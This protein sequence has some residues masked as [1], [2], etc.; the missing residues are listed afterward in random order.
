MHAPSLTVNSRR[1]MGWRLD[2]VA[3]FVVALLG[4]TTMLGWLLHLPALTEIR[5][6]LVPMVFNTGLGFLLAGTALLLPLSRG[7]QARPARTLIASL[8]IGLCGLT[9]IELLLDRSL[10]GIDLAFLHEW[11]DYGN[12]RPGRMA[13]N[14][15]L[16]F[17]VVAGAILMAD[18]V[19][20]RATAL[21]AIGLTF[22][23]LAIGMTGLVGYLLA[24]DLLFDWAR[25][26]RMALHTASGMILTALGL[27]LAWSRSDWY[28]SAGLI[29][30]YAKVRLLSGAILILVTLTAALA[31]F[32]LQ[33]QSVESALQ[34]RMA[35]IVRA[36][37][38]WLKLSV[39]QAE[40]HA[41]ETVE[42]LGL[43]AQAQQ[44]LNPAREALMQ[45][46]FGPQADHLL[47]SGWQRVALENAAGVSLMAA[48]KPVA[49]SEFEAPLDAQGRA[50]LL[51]DGQLVLR[52]R[53]PL[54]PLQGGAAALALASPPAPASAQLVL[55]RAIPEIGTALL[56][57]AGMGQTGEIAAC[58]GRGKQLLCLPTRTM[59][60]LFAVTPRPP[61]TTPLP[62][63]RSV[64]GEN[65]VSQSVDYQGH[66]VLAAYG[67][68]APGLGFVAKQDTV[69]IYAGIRRALA[70]GAPLIVLVVVLG[71]GFMAWQLSP[72]VA[73]M[74]Q[75]EES[76]SLAS[77]KTQA[78][79]DSAGDGI[80]TVDG[81]GVI[82]LANL[83]ACRM[84]GYRESELLGEPVARLIPDQGLQQLR[85]HVATGISR[86]VGQP[87]IQVEAV[88][89][90]GS[91]FP[92]ELT[93]SA[94]SGERHTLFVG[95]MRDIQVRKE[96]EE[97]LER[98]A[99]YDALTELPN[100]ALF[101]DRLSTALIR[102]TRHRHALAV[103]FLDLDGFKA[104][105]DTFGHHEGDALL[106]Q[107]AQRLSQAVRKSDTVARLAGDE[108]TVILEDL[109]QPEAD[110]QAV[111]R[112]I[113]EAMRVPFSIAGQPRVMTVS[114]GAVLRQ[115]GA[116][117]IDIPALLRCADTAMYEAKRAGK[118]DVKFALAD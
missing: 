83:A 46:E 90:D 80:L 37:G 3:G 115:P 53:L 113:L 76:A 87:N 29:S 43:P 97:R 27:W 24:P 63:Q 5:S 116:V 35:A 22:A 99:Q 77:L 21:A 73:R 96:L 79:V 17:L 38:P 39:A 103:M 89:K 84:F 69:E 34:D 75:A 64:A 10:L 71:V 67:Q 15:A 118:N 26:A 58:I 110:A 114:I 28:V 82:E 68:L 65:G 94:V 101:L 45:R 85:P 47:H 19:R 111:A 42:L 4:A 52:L 7:E 44:W 6:G 55:E 62:I 12:K 14:T 117:G 18:R 108:F 31:G 32:V 70:V 51:W 30:E 9:L 106:V 74:R 57:T 88:R 104:I 98:L 23:V 81:Q 66:N 54:Q 50:A 112:K 72:L 61:G 13:P 20:S 16:G 2:A 78:I 86:W 102:A 95:V 59:P 25:S 107:V 92:L 48:G 100:R 1:R 109:V 49:A 33:Q 8:L 11:Y 56:T 93:F 40:Q 41:R 36:R 91:H 105:N 60:Q